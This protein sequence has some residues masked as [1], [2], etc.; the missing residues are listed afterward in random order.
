MT[1]RRI[2]LL[3]L[4]GS[5]CTAAVVVAGCATETV[6]PAD[7]PSTTANAPLP[8]DVTFG[9]QP[10]A[11]TSTAECNA[12]AGL[13]PDPLP[14]PRQMPPGSTMDRIAK[15]GRLVVG[16]DL[17]SNPLSFRDPISGDVKGFDIDVA[18]WI[19]AAIFGDPNLIEYRMIT[20]DNRSEALENGTVDIVVKTMSITCDRLKTVSFSV[21]YYAASQQIL[22][23]RNSG[24]SQA[25]DLAGKNVCATRSS[26]SIAR[27]QEAVP[28]AKFIT[29]ASWADCLVMMQQ[30]QVDA[31]TSDDPILAG[32][33][34]QDPWVQVVGDSL[35]TEYYGVGIPKGQDDLVRFV[36][37]VL[38]AR[39]A[40][41]SWQR[42]YNEWLSILGP[43][44]P[45]PTTYRD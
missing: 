8:P 29:T 41:G 31:I 1:D 38:A 33:A 32:I 21:P 28:S 19:S 14:E 24:I 23:Y 5:I 18:H 37:G 34:A 44:Y 39:E 9:A 22:A 10:D 17:G 25:S 42:S 4:A 3:A 15:R 40:D 11:P 12:T 7:P 27:V 43:G 35:G 13:R 26:T 16:T 2:R 45:P 6:S 20:N 30:G 36:N